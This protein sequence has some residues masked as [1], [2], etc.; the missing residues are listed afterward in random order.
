MLWSRV[1]EIALRHFI[2][3]DE[4]YILV[5]KLGRYAIKMLLFKMDTFINVTIAKTEKKPVI[6]ALI[7]ETRRS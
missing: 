4:I 1:V 3:F 2:S 7:I 6:S 5:L